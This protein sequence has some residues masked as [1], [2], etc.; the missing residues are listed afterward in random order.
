MLMQ[1]GFRRKMLYICIAKRRE[2][3]NNGLSPLLWLKINDFYLGDKNFFGLERIF[4][5]LSWCAHRLSRKIFGLEIIKYIKVFRTKKFGFN[6]CMKV[7]STS[8]QCV[9][10]TSRYSAEG[11]RFSWGSIARLVTS[12]IEPNLWCDRCECGLVSLKLYLRSM[13][14]G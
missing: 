5:G 4:F 8:W 12:V 13:P 11:L 10:F 1:F 2:P 7:L 9:G 3:V 14:S 6:N